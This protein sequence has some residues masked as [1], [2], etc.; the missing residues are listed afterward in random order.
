LPEQEVITSGELWQDGQLRDDDS[1]YDFFEQCLHNPIRPRDILLQKL[2]Q[3][4]ASLQRLLLEIELTEEER[5][6]GEEGVQVL[7]E[8][9]EK[10][11]E[12]E[13]LSDQK[14]E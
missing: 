2:K 6:V 8:L 5:T 14:S 11:I 13:P 3:D 12:V 7:G 10:L 1:I 4:K 9:C